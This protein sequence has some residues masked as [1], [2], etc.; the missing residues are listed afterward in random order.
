MQEAEKPAA[1]DHK[2]LDIAAVLAEANLSTT[3]HMY[4]QYGTTDEEDVQTDAVDSIL[5][6]VDFT[7]LAAESERPR[8]IGDQI[9]IQDSNRP[10][11]AADRFDMEEAEIERYHDQQVAE[12][13]QPPPRQLP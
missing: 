8:V 10:L 5:G 11:I 7:Q 4:N 13:Q 1:V 9:Y 6:S 3:S 2:N 12:R